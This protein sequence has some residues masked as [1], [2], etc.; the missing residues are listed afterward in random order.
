[1]NILRHLLGER[2]IEPI[3]AGGA[4]VPA[5][6][7]YCAKICS[8]V[9]TSQFCIILLNNDTSDGREVPNANVNME[10][11]LMLGFNKYIIPF[12]REAQTLPFNVAGLDTIR[13]SNRDFEDKARHA[14]DIAIQNT[15]QE[16]ALEIPPDQLLESFLLSQQVLVAPIDNDGERNI[17]QLGQPLGFKLLMSFD[18]MQYRYFGNFTALRAEIVVW[19]VRTLLT[20]VSARFGSISERVG[21]GLAN[22]GVNELA[23]LQL[24]LEQLQI[25]LFVTSDEERDAVKAVYPDSSSGVQIKVFSM[26]D[27]VATLQ[28]P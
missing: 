24:L 3:E 19:R 2:S 20:I 21:L 15:S 14:I 5:Q 6:N 10:Y 9:I 16:N 13:Y 4:L 8:K 18:G 23:V 12:Q 28:S 25:W 7:V 17:F 11:G 22:V 1:M 27:I 26:S